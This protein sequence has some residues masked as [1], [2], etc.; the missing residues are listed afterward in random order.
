[1]KRTLKRVIKQGLKLLRGKAL[2]TNRAWSIQQSESRVQ[3][4]MHVSISWR[5]GRRRRARCPSFG[6]DPRRSHHRAD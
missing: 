1:M 6:G 4:F 3:S 5:C 2:E